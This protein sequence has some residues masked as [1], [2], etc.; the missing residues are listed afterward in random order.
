VT[1]SDRSPSA[2]PTPASKQHGGTVTVLGAGPSGLAAA[3]TLAR[4][5]Q[6]VRVIEQRSDV[7]GRYDGNLQMLTNYPDDIDALAEL[8]DILG[9]E[10]ALPKTWPQYGAE[11]YGPSGKLSRV[12][13]ELPFGY[14][15]QR[16]PDSAAL[17]GA[18]RDAA[19]SVGVE[20]HFG[21]RGDPAKA[22]I[23][24]TGGRRV[25]GVA[26]EWYG[27]VDL[28]DGFHVR[29]D[30]RVCPGGYGY[31]LVADGRAVL[32]AAVVREH[33]RIDQ[34]FRETADWFSQ[35]VGLPQIEEYS[36]VGS[37]DLFAI[38]S[39]IGEPGNLF[40]G[41]AGG[42]CDGL[43]GFGIRAA[44]QSGRLAA[45][46]LI[47]KSEFDQQWRSYYDRRFETSLANRFIF[48]VGGNIL[49]RALLKV[50]PYLDFRETGRKLACSSP[51]RGHLM[52][53][54]KRFWASDPST[55]HGARAAWQR[56]V[57]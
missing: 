38:Q 31:L 47:N 57:K 17:D 33:N 10:H 42:F 1:E 50:A 51:I 44:L 27:S 20:I 34:A 45:D 35:T 11:L 48:E 19:T 7:G 2:H 49:Y 41:E 40:I 28:P 37:V 29:F 3:I 18:L 15:L 21:E 24:A 9:G 4:A 36:F 5:G 26:R 16:G 30:A 14:M 54:I 46:S 52:P 55:P 13:S 23:V 22:D 12:Q 8:A 53:V 25:Q 43:F 39:A 56:L 32:G 6:T